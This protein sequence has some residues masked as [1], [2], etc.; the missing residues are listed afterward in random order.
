MRMIPT[1]WKGSFG[2]HNTFRRDHENDTH[3]LEGERDTHRKMRMIL[4]VWKGAR[5]SWCEFC[6]PCCDACPNATG[7]NNHAENNQWCVDQW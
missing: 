3:C 5:M 1:V 7:N 2:F 6:P 4:T